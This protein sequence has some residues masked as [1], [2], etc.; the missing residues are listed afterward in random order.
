MGEHVGDALPGGQQPAGS[1]EG[2]CLQARE[3]RGRR[4]GPA[5]QPATQPATPGPLHLEAMTEAPQGP[6]LP[7]S[8]GSS[9]ECGSPLLPLSLPSPPTGCAL[10]RPQEVSLGGR[11]AGKCWWN[12]H[13]RYFKGR[14]QQVSWLRLRFTPCR[15]RGAAL[16]GILPLRP[17]GARH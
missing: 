17:L 4:P 12:H 8:H 16:T 7:L 15:S 1:N 14:C 2:A 13:T 9:E 10:Q 3:A 11:Q 5:A 6:C